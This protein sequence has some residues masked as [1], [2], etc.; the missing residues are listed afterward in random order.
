MRRSLLCLSLIMVFVSAA[1][2]D[3]VTLKN[4]DRLSGNIVSGDGKNLLIKTEFAGDVTIQ[5]DA[6]GGIESTQN[7]HLTLKDGT[8]LSGK[9]TTTPDGK[10]VV[11]G[12]APAPAAPPSRD[13]IVAVRNDAEQKTFDIDAEKMAHPKFTYFWSGLFD[14]GLA[15]T[16]GNSSTA[17][18]TLDG[19]GVRETPRDKLTLYAN[20]IFAD[21]QVT[22][23]ATTTAN[24]FQAGIR[25][26]LNVGPR[27]F[28]YA[29]ADFA[30]NQ[31]QHL[32]LR[33]VYGG[34]AGYHVIKNDNTLFDIFGGFDYDKDE[35]GSYSYVNT[36]PPPPIF[37]VAS[38]TLNS[39]EAVVGEEF[40][41]KMSKRMTLLERFSFYP[42]ISHT[43]D[44]R[45]Q[46]NASLAVMMKTW[47]SWQT[48]FSDQ[49]ISY[50][51]PGLK[52]NDLVLS[53]GL[54]VTWGKA[55]L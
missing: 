30:T 6:I 5:W 11:A 12:A 21:N 45:M 48:S 16:R 8:K 37:S 49:Y 33:Q 46:F 23:P 54:R 4:G 36:A 24:L 19:K 34:G 29:T 32:S 7:L 2:A 1:A 42:N 51:P 47:L 40:D 55:K 10:F 50:P 39:A 22:V 25:G 13:T 27:A 17:S 14:T 44:Y 9:I 52:G 38:Y 41:T 35:F 26:D 15:L 43:G 3:Q 28:V 53:T 18:Y 31:L 20:Y